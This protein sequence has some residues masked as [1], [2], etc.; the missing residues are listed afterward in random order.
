MCQMKEVSQEGWEVSALLDEMKRKG[1]N[2]AV[3]LSTVGF[4]KSKPQFANTDYFDNLPQLPGATAKQFER[5]TFKMNRW[6]QMQEKVN[7]QR[8]ESQMRHR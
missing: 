1:S 8:E 6:T 5:A 2:Q 4:D 7:K 3:A